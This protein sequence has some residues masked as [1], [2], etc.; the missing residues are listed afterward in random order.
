MTNE[1]LITAARLIDSG[2]M[3]SYAKRVVLQLADALEAATTN[4]KLIVGYEY[5]WASNKFDSHFY[6]T[7][8][9][10]KEFID[11][12]KWCRR[13]KPGLWEVVE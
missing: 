9:Y 12:P 11:D 1:D 6:E 5:G 10:A 8:E 2:N 3:S 4:S 13:I 7:E